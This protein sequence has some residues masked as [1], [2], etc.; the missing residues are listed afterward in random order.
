M[1]G[2]LASFDLNL[3][4]G[5]ATINSFMKPVIYQLFVRHFSN[6]TQGGQPWGSRAD[7]GCGTFQGITD[8]ALEAIA[9]MGV[10]HLWLTG[11]L[12]HATQTAYPGLDASPACV[13]KGRAGSPYAVTDYYDVDPDLSENPDTRLE[14]FA[15]LLARCRRWGMVPMIDFIP[16]H[17]SRC[18]QSTVQR[19]AD[20]GTLDDKGCFFS[21]DNTFYYLEPCHSDHRMQLPDGEF[22][23][24][25]GCGRVTGNNAATW[26]PGAFDWYETVKL[27]Y[28]TDY[29]FGAYAADNLP[30]IMAS[31]AFVPAT[32][33]RMDAVLAYWQEM[34]VGGFR[35]DMA[36]MV[37][38]PFWRWA[39]AR[40]RIRNAG[41]FFM[42]E[43]YDDHMKLTQ[44]DLIPTLLSAGFQGVYDSKAYQSLRSLYEGNLW[45]ND[46]D[47]QNRAELPTFRG[48][49]RY[50][51]NHDEPRVAASGY[52][53]GVGESVI[54]ALMV[55]QYTT[56]AGPVLLYNGQETGER[57]E[58]PGGYGGDNGRTSIFDYTSL[59][60]FQHWT[61]GGCY[62]G[63]RMTPKERS[64][65]QYT[66][67]LLP[68][69]QHPAIAQGG[70]YGLNWANLQTPG[71]GRL[72]GEQTSGHYLYAYLRHN[73]KARATVLVVCNLSPSDDT[74]ELHIHIP[75]HAQEWAGK[76]PGSYH[77]M[78]L[79]DPDFPAIQSDDNQLDQIGLPV[80]LPPGTALLL[81]WQ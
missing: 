75:R 21:R 67:K 58:G 81:E 6:F 2:F 5:Y 24:E 69:L 54:R 41:V 48:G 79:L 77:F 72:N 18:Y 34:G 25:R 78:N 59:P 53:G 3:L 42:A 26:T 60:R 62:D 38:A 20:W 19:E 47:A 50:V 49:V 40:A 35:C 37:P 28:G 17:V 45:A 8:A 52:W 4:F 51:E 23:P 1:L 10:T 80:Q 7:N 39:I 44:G 14:A 64:L 55:L 9:H 31:E 68:C 22:G 32:W 12:R 11:A 27:N 65:R 13:V 57:A 76:K 66:A 16:N 33:R 30:G 61:N 56:T 74:V 73:P 43:A 63:A 46:L 36:H 71:Y 70:F 29:R 15:D